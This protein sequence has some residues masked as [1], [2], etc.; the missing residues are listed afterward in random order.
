MVYELF[1]SALSPL[2]SIQPT[3]SRASGRSWQNFLRRAWTSGEKKFFY[4]TVNNTTTTGDGESAGMFLSNSLVWNRSNRLWKNMKA[5]NKSKLIANNNKWYYDPAQN[6]TSWCPCT[7]TARTAVLL[8]KF[9][10]HFQYLDYLETTGF[11]TA[12]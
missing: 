8:W 12:F 4:W 1:L 10:N 5:E 2:L 7:I 6:L 9:T 11:H 3:C